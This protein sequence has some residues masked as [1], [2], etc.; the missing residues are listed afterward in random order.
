MIC[1]SSILAHLAKFLV[2]IGCMR[3]LGNKYDKASIWSFCAFQILLSHSILGTFRF[4]AP[5]LTSATNVAKYLRIFYDWY[6]KIVDIVPL[7]LFTAGILQ[8]YGISEKVWLLVLSLGILPVFFLLQPKQKES[9]IK[10]HQLLMNITNTLQLLMITLFTA[11][12]LQGYGISEKIWLIILSLG[13]W[14]LFFHLQPKQ[15]ETQ[16]RRH[17]LLMNITTTLQ[18]LMITLIGLKNSNYNVISLVVSYIF[19][20]FFIDEFCYYYDIP[21]TDLTQYSLCFVEIFMVF[22]LNEV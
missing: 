3:T 2:T 18:L 8:G 17:Q 19:E 10:N 11:G 7:A 15:K 16:I 12:I 9:Q 5:F 21:S 6:S 14:P 1:S 20:R 4:G 13:I 22:T